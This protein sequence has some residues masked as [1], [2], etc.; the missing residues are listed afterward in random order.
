MTT[1]RAASA[2]TPS[3]FCALLAPW[4]LL[5]GLLSPP[6]VTQAARVTAGAAAPMASS[7]RRV[8]YG[9]NRGVGFICVGLFSQAVRRMRPAY[10]ASVATMCSRPPGTLAD[11]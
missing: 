2:G 3:G 10:R 7:V 8:G 1:S 11:R 4:L 9:L 6:L 5:V